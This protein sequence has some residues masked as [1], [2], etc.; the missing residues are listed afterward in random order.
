MQWQQSVIWFREGGSA[1]SPRDRLGQPSLTSVIAVVCVSLIRESNYSRKQATSSAALYPFLI[2]QNVTISSHRYWIRFQINVLWVITH[3]TLMS[4]IREKTFRRDILPT[5]SGSQWVCSYISRLWS[6][7]SEVRREDRKAAGSFETSY[8]SRHCYTQYTAIWIAMA[9][10]T[11]KFVS[12]LIKVVCRRN[13]SALF[14]V[15]ACYFL[16]RILYSY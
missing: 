9:G 1:C 4:L 14:C 2:L 16:M 8:P 3:C 5:S 11:L 15:T 12:N 13:L 10:K 6:V 7:R